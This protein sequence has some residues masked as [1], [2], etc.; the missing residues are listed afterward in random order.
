MNELQ[1]IVDA[2]RE[3]RARGERTALATVVG[4]EGSA[5]RR[6]GARML[7]TEGG[8]T[9][10]TISGGCLERDVVERAA[11]VSETG[12]ARVVVYD[13][14]GDEDIVWGLGLGCNGVVRVLLEGLH[15]GSDGACAL[16]FV[17]N[18]LRSR[19]RGVVA[20]VIGYAGASDGACGGFRGGGFRIG[21][22]F[23]LDGDELSPCDL[24][25]NGL[26]LRDREQ[27]FGGVFGRVSEDARKALAGGRAL[28]R[29][30]EADEGVEVF[31][32]VIE[33]P[34]PLLV[35]GAE[36]DALPLVR[37]ARTLGWHT[38]VVDT[39]ARG[40]TRERFAEADEVILCRAEEIAARLRLPPRAAAVLMTHNYLHDVEL[41]RALLPAPLS[42]LGV[43]GPKER[44]RKLL[45]E[46]RAQ[47]EAFPGH[48]PARLHSP[49]GVDIGAETP[50]EVALSIVAEI[51][52]M[53][54][55]RRAGFLRDR[56]APIH[57]G[58]S[59]TLEAT[60]VSVEPRP[61][62]ARE[63]ASVMVCRSS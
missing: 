10:G 57:D 37:L 54:A 49:V 16:Q 8:Q 38:T 58:F 4:V 32:D 61:V 22:R 31:F 1:A 60:E 11:R 13:T 18:R 2:Y 52:A 29:R 46:L 7:I 30:Y 53:F 5:Y 47:G 17:A 15:E 27:P 43:L 59:A 45:G 24:D 63:S 34:R 14:R 48:W 41:L 20:T 40:T 26:N 39:R 25:G 35:F 55:G 56:D 28:V 3:A 42:Y 33:P 36:Q 21:E 19:R 23:F 62:A 6:P 51:R 12:A 9:T 50:E 44:T